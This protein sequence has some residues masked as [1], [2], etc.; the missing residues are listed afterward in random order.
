VLSPSPVTTT[1]CRYLRT[2]GQGA[3]G[4]SWFATGSR[5]VLADWNGWL[6]AAA[7]QPR[8]GVQLTGI[9]DPSV[10]ET[11]R[12]L[13]LDV[14][15]QSTINP[16]RPVVINLY[17]GASFCTGG[18]GATVREALVSLLYKIAPG[19]AN[20]TLTRCQFAVSVARGYGIKTD[21]LMELELQ[22]A[23]GD[24]ALRRLRAAGHNY[25]QLLAK[26]TTTLDDEPTA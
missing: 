7:G 20:F 23:V 4:L 26:L 15:R 25:Q 18:A 13:T 22:A 3:P 2:P 6:Q 21:G 1:P 17:D 24:T 10:D 12:T 16:G 9:I 19:E 5:I 11:P 14:N 8:F